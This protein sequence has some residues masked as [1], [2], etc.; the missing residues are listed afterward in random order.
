M[1]QGVISNRIRFVL[2]KQIYQKMYQ[3]KYIYLSNIFTRILISANQN[4]AF[5]KF[6]FKQQI[7]SYYNCEALVAQWLK[8]LIS[9]SA[10]R[11]LAS[12]SRRLPKDPHRAQIN[13]QGQTCDCLALAVHWPGGIGRHPEKQPQL[14]S[15]LTIIIS[16][17]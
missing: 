6:K 3:Q 5:K 2:S 11:W 10:D 15:I 12:G 9:A 13:A 8:N 7:C 4:R 1:P 14:S 16:N 17:T